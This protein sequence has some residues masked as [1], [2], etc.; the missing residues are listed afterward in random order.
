V[1]LLKLALAVC[2][3][4]YVL[5]LATASDATWLA[6]GAAARAANLAWIVV[7]GAATY[8]AALWLLGFRLADFARR[9]AD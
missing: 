7:L 6:M 2:A 8:F 4:S 9:A 3:M 1:F 5:W